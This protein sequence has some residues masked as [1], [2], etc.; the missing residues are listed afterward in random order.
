M[1]TGIPRM[2]GNGAEL[3]GF[4]SL[5]NHNM[6]AIEIRDT[7]IG[8][9]PSHSD[10]LFQMFTRLNSRDRFEGTGLGLALCKKIVARH[11]G[12][13][14]AKGTENVGASFTVVM[15]VEEPRVDGT[16]PAAAGQ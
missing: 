15:P 4:A 10:R 11:H 8:F 5:G 13:I 1:S 16:E 14:L 7:G 9:D 3:N 6:V 2:T 12:M